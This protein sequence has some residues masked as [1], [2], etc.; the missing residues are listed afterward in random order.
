MMARNWKVWGV[1]GLLLALGLTIGYG[2]KA[3]PVKQTYVLTSVHTIDANNN[4][5]LFI[6]DNDVHPTRHM[7]YQASQFPPANSFPG[8]AFFF[9]GWPDTQPPYYGGAIHLY[10][11]NLPGNYN[12]KVC[13]RMFPPPPPPPPQT[14]PQ[15]FITATASFPLPLW[16]ASPTITATPNCQCVSGPA[17]TGPVGSGTQWIKWT[18]GLKGNSVEFCRLEVEKS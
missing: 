4:L 16:S 13:F 7:A 1:L 5:K 8:V 11:E 9:P 6:F 2:Q 10:I 3:I 14:P 17:P 12:F 18:F 15:L